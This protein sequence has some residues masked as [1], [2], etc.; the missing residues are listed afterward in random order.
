[1][2]NPFG[3]FMITPDPAR[4][5]AIVLPLGFVVKLPLPPEE[6]A[7]IAWLSSPKVIP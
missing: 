2:E 7:R 4:K 5:Y 1:L 3:T 6:V